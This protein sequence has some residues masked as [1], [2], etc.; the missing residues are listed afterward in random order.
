MQKLPS[1]SVG[2]YGLVNSLLVLQCSRDDVSEKLKK[3]LSTSKACH[4]ANPKTLEFQVRHIAC[5]CVQCLGISGYR[6]VGNKGKPV[7]M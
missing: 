4:I 3:P 6:E 7:L 5:L 1:T 2:N